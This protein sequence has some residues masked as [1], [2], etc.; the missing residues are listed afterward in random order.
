MKPS[1]P[2]S[3]ATIKK[4]AGASILRQ[5]CLETG[6]PLPGLVAARTA[7]KI[8]VK[9]RQAD[10]NTAAA[11]V[12][13]PVTGVV[14]AA[15]AGAV[16]LIAAV[17]RAMTAAMARAVGLIAAVTGVVSATMT[18]RVMLLAAVSRVVTAAVALVGVAVVVT[19][20]R[21]GR[22]EH[23]KADGDSEKGDELFHDEWWFAFDWLPHPCGV[24][25]RRGAAEPIRDSHILF[26]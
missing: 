13:R 1:F 11:A 26:L 14:T 16:R 12:T 9:A 15:M 18:W 10:V 20:L 17:P 3:P 21:R 19:S 23:G 22:S 5:A 2:S 6:H 7:T 4:P 25:I 8:D 24:F